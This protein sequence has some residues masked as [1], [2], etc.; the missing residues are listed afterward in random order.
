MTTTQL[1]NTVENKPL[2]E[3]TE[4]L[5]RLI[6]DLINVGAGIHDYVGTQQAY[7]ALIHR[8]NNIILEL[9]TL[10]S[11]NLPYPIPIDVINYIED[12]RNPDIYTREFIEVN[13]KSNARLKGRMQNFGKLRDILGDKLVSEFPDLK[14]T[15][16]G[17]KTRT[18]N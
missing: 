7:Q 1:E 3:T 13:A 5:Q 14:E 8:F 9:S 2:I 18:S 6:D 17:I 10:S 11:N 15:I 12:G 4:Q 16:E